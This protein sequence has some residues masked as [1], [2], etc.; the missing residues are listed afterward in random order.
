MEI[1][2]K[3]VIFTRCLYMNSQG[4]LADGKYQRIIKNIRL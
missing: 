4:N 2:D 3:I 1:E